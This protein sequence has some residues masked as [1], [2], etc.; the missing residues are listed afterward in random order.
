VAVLV[1]VVVVVVVVVV[2]TIFVVVMAPVLLMAVC[3][4][5]R[6]LPGIG[7]RPFTFP[8]V[9]GVDVDQVCD[10]QMNECGVCAPRCRRTTYDAPHPRRRCAVMLLSLV[11][12]ALVMLLPGRRVRRR[13]S[14][15]R[16]GSTERL[17]LVPHYLRTNWIRCA[18]TV[19]SRVH[20]CL[21]LLLGV[22]Q[23][24]VCHRNAAFFR[25]MGMGGSGSI[26]MMRSATL[27]LRPCSASTLTI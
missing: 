24:G 9:F 17:Q 14:R 26:G 12:V 7:V 20:A 4:C 1:A 6:Y 11:T 13:R 5:L 25:R 16:V 18:P 8:R 3:L 15:D 10:A 27:G 21:V 22:L 19:L 23:P 2:V